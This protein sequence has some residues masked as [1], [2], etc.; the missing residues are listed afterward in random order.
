MVRV[1]EFRRRSWP[2][3]YR[4][5]TNDYDQVEYFA[6][7]GWVSFEEAGISTRKASHRAALAARSEAGR[8]PRLY[9]YDLFVGWIAAT[10]YGKKWKAATHR[11]IHRDQL[12]LFARLVARAEKDAAK[13]REQSARRRMRMSRSSGSARKTIVTAS[14]R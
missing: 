1:R 7:A 3:K 10:S 12:P 8:P 4:L 2:K 13:K 11:I 5:A 6:P 14:A 9:T